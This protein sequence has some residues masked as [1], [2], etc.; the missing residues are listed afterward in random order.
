MDEAVS[1]ARRTNLCSRSYIKNDPQGKRLAEAAR[2]ECLKN[3]GLNAVGKTNEVTNIAQNEL[4]AQ[5]ESTAKRLQAKR[6]FINQQLIQQKL[7][8]IDRQQKD[9]Y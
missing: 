1:M 7:N 9:G 3:A 4:G 5:N 8:D 2:D 6:E